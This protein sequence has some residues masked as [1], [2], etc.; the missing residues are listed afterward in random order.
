MTTMKM[1]FGCVLLMAITATVACSGNLPQ[2][3]KTGS[4][5]A[6]LVCDELEKQDQPDWV[7]YGCE[8]VDAGGKV[9]NFFQARVRKDAKA[10]FAAR[11]ARPQHK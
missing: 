8:A 4:G 11:Y 7:E 5:I 3:V 1:V 6:N 9:I 2:D 10:N